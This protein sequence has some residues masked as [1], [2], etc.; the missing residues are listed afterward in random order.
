MSF[1]ALEILRVDEIRIRRQPMFVTLTATVGVSRTNTG[2]AI[3][4]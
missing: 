4:P 2:I 3:A 1:V